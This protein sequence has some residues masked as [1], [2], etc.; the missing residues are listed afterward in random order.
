M[1]CSLAV[2]ISAK[3][4]RPHN[5]PKSGNDLLRYV[6]RLQGFIHCSIALSQEPCSDHAR[7]QEPQA[8]QD[9][10]ALDGGMVVP[11][12]T[13]EEQMHEKPRM[14]SRPALSHRMGSG[15]SLGEIEAQ[16]VVAEPSSERGTREHKQEFWGVQASAPAESVSPTVQEEHTQRHSLSLDS[17]LSSLPGGESGGDWDFRRPVCGP[18]THQLY[19][20]NL[21]IICSQVLPAT[22]I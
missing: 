11:Q 2:A 22:A 4:T 12:Q 17:G 10:R 18:A 1:K 15:I 21:S 6:S 7:E 16:S 3:N 19:E 8:K 14:K 5:S 13:R 20:S 9:H